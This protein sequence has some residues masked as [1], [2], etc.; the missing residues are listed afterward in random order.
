MNAKKAKAIVLVISGAACLAAAAA[1]RPELAAYPYKTVVTSGGTY[2]NGSTVGT[3][4]VVSGTITSAL[5][6]S[7]DVPY[8]VTL[9][10]ATVSAP[11]TLGGDA[12]LWLKGTS[13]ITT[14]KAAA[15]TSTGT[16]TVGGTGSAVL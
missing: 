9:N 13:T 12:T 7:S 8:R 10:G 6:F 3:D 4:F 5:T 11:V 1:G 2:A 16:L 15:L 14:S